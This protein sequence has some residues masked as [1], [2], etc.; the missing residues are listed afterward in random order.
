M[1]TVPNSQEVPDRLGRGKFALL[2]GTR[3]LRF[4]GLASLLVLAIVGFIAAGRPGLWIGLGPYIVLIVVDVI[5]SSSAL[6]RV[7]RQLDN[8]QPCACMFSGAPGTTDQVTGLWKACRVQIGSTAQGTRI[9]VPLARLS[10]DV[11]AERRSTACDADHHARTGDDAFDRVVCI[12]SNAGTWRGV[13]TAE[14]RRLLLALCS[15]TR[16][17]LH[18]KAL[19]VQLTDAAAGELGV[20]LDLAVAFAA[21]LP[22]LSDEDPRARV[23]ALAAAE[24]LGAVRAGHYR[25]LAEQGWNT[26]QVH[27][28]AAAD[29]D[30]AIAA[31]GASQLAPSDGVFR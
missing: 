13:L 22:A 11:M 31:W 4:G 16:T 1:T 8:A 20:V 29:A 23:F 2:N 24:P 10:A 9:G 25:W 5:R 19:D 7:K 12:G 6:G 30:P 21:A 3:A 26:S 17:T 14:P 15:R 27:R 28:A 18:D